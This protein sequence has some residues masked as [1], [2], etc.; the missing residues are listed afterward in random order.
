MGVPRYKC[1]Y[2]GGNTSRKERICSPCYEKLLL[3]RKLLKMVKSYY[4][5]YK[6]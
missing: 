6:A 1:K 5:R 4:R 3:I 2:C